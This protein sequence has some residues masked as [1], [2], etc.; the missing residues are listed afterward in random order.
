MTNVN[1]ANLNVTRH[2]LSDVEIEF[3]IHNIVTKIEQINL[4]KNI[5]C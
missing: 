4:L 2:G 1:T 3:M 5:S